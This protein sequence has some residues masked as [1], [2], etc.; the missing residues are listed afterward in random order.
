MTVMFHR[1]VSFEFMVGTVVDFAGGG[2]G[3]E[4]YLIPL[5]LELFWE[6]AHS[7]GPYRC[8][9]VGIKHSWD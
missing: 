3:V 4:M 8:C 9:L 2:G 7:S 1:S 5:S 6:T